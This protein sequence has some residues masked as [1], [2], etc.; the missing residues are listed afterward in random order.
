[1]LLTFL[2][3]TANRAALMARNQDDKGASQAGQVLTV[4]LK[5]APPFVFK[6][7][8]GNWTGVSVALWKDIAAEENL[9]FQF[10][11]YQLEGLLD[12]LANEQVD[13]SINPLSV[14]SKRLD[15]MDFTQPFFITSFAIAVPAE[16]QSALMQFL[17][18]LFSVDFFKAVL[19]LFLVILIFGLL[20]WLFER[21]KNP[22]MFEEGLSGIWSGIWWS[23]VTM[24]TV[25]YGDK[26]PATTGGKIIA[27]IWMFT[28]IIIISSFTAGIASSLTVGQ[29]ETDIQSPSDL[30]DARV[31][32]LG[33]SASE[34]YLRERGISTDEYPNLA[35]A[36][37]GLQAGQSDALVYDEP[38]LRY[39]L[40]QIGLQ[41]S[42]T[43]L[44]NTFNKQ[45][46][47]FA[48]R[49][50]HPLKP[51]IDKKVVEKI[52]TPAFRQIKKRFKL[53][54]EDF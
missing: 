41:Q 10:K 21:R 44:P 35:A 25:G 46:Y 5:E 49:S 34:T 32:T 37:E 17:E 40:H 16:D 47:A 30:Y 7:E 1:M 43:I 51:L 33:G 45:Y 50:G 29:L 2:V 13:L 42:I 15:R 27:L 22:E 12:A 18:N 31:A 23:A 38:I 19:L 24:T 39:Q 9:R 4:G 53:Q 36:L 8:Q 48:L 28:A 52:K 3:I 26:A 6:D 54:G 11:A 14:S 20:V